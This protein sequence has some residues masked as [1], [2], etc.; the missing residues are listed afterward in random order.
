MKKK[1]VIAIA[2]AT[3]ILGAALAAT[4]VLLASPGKNSTSGNSQ[5]ST[6]NASPAPDAGIPTT[7]TA[8]PPVQ[9]SPADFKVD[10]VV[11]NKECFGPAGCNY[12]YTI[13]PHYVGPQPM[14]SEKAT[15]IYQVNGA[16]D[17]EVGNFTIDKWGTAHFDKQEL[18]IAPDDT[19]FTATITQVLPF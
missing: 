13:D 6:P 12:T 18:A 8:P 3:F 19:T 9:L 15:V 4:I 5:P 1:N 11:T 10:I 2:A 16:G 14:P 17:D 7:T